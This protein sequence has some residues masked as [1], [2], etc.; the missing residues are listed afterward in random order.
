MAE[1]RDILTR[2]APPPDT[3]LRYGEL[4]DQVAD[5]W[6][7][8][9]SGPLVLC[10]HGGYWRPA[11]DRSYTGSLAADL[12]SRG[13]AV[14]NLEYRRGGDWADTMLDVAAGAD[15]VPGLVGRTEVVYTGHSAGGHLAL[16]AALR[17]RLPDGAPGRRAEPP[18]VR[19]V[20]ALAPVA[21]VA[22]AYR[23]HLDLGAARDFLGG[24]PRAY[25]E[26]Y[27]AVDPA[28]LGAPEVPTVLVHGRADGRVPIALSREYAAHHEG[29]RLVEVDADHFAVVDPESSAWPTVLTELAALAGR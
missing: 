15:A 10:W 17:H 4:P 14:A 19:G 21:E 18:A 20:L 27:A 12:A 9:G 2:T 3:T 11:H 24:A 16:W 1:H 25:P 13:Y 7:P 28:G 23:R 22:E 29:V 26:R 6:L 5:V 8:A